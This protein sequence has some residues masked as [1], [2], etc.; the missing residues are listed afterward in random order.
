MNN[1]PW[2]TCII[3][4]IF[5]LVFAS[6]LPFSIPYEVILNEISIDYDIVE[7][8]VYE[9]IW[10]IS[11]INIASNGVKPTIVNGDNVFYIHGSESIKGSFVKAI[12][13]VDGKL[14]WE[15]NLNTIENGE[16]IYSDGYIFLGVGG[17][18]Q[19]LALDDSGAILWRKTIGTRSVS[20]LYF[21][22][23]QLNIYTASQNFY[24]FDKEGNAIRERTFESEN[25]FFVE[26][27]IKYHI[28]VNSFVAVN[29]VTNEKIWEVEVDGN[30]LGKPIFEHENIFYVSRFPLK[31]ISM[32]R[33]SGFVNWVKE[34]FVLSNLCVM[35]TKIY[36]IDYEG[37]LVEI[38]KING[39]QLSKVKFNRSV[40]SSRQAYYIAGDVENNILAIAFG[41]ERQV[42]GLKISNP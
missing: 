31:I 9:K 13:S 10:E 39:E 15:T 35:D 27:N 2:K 19:I 8:S 22:N 29:E 37:Y 26:N 1:N 32:N 40:D 42:L 24:I 20:N 11:E 17:L 33:E 5:F 21:V 3:L 16:I 30:L 25:V 36:F 41:L 18:P 38:N 4:S 34:Y 23:D 14:I 12:Q 6:C 28:D 7:N